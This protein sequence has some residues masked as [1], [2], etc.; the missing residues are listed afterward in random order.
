MK[1]PEEL[2]IE[3]ETGRLAFIESVL[4]VSKD[5][6]EPERIM[7]YLNIKDVEDFEKLISKMEK[8]YKENG[9]GIMHLRFGGQ[10]DTSA[11][12][13]NHDASSILFIVL[14]HF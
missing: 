3:T 9:R 6:V 12:S 1:D 4:F 2:N 5:P 7:N 10:L 11:G 8:N 14:F 13:L